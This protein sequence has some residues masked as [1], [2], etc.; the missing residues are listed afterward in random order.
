MSRL[1]LFLMIA[2]SFFSCGG[3]DDNEIPQAVIDKA[4]EEASYF[5][6]IVE[7]GG[8]KLTEVYNIPPFSDVSVR[9]DTTTQKFNLGLN[10]I[11]YLTTYFNI[12]ET[13]VDEK[14]HPI[15]KIGGGQFLG[16]LSNIKGFKREYTP[17][18][19][20]DLET[21]ENYFMCFL[22]RSYDISLKNPNASFLFKIKADPKGCITESNLQDTAYALISPRNTFAGNN[23]NKILIDFYLK[24][25]SISKGGNY[26]VLSIDDTTFKL[27]KWA[28]FYLEGLKLGKHTIKLEVFTKEGKKINSIF[29]NETIS[30]IDLVS[31]DIFE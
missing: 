12:G 7:H 15:K 22:S 17:T 27:Y 30:I 10:Q 3:D 8:L 2:F 29:P 23:T 6:I 20:A 9:L 19:Q 21:G 26:A 24:N 13:T 14:D 16:V 31:V 25:I 4:Q 28:A 5:P 1:I 11:E 18:I